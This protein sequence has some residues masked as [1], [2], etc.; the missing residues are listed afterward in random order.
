MKNRHDSDAR[1]ILA[2]T[3]AQWAESKS[4]RTAKAA[5]TELERAQGAVPSMQRDPTLGGKVFANYERAPNPVLFH[6]EQDE[7]RRGE[8]TVLREVRL[9]ISRD[10]R[11][12]IE[13][14]NG[15]GKT[16]LL[17]ALV[18]ESTRPDRILHL[19]QE[20]SEGEVQ[21]A[22][23]ELR[24]LAPEPRGQLLS[25]FAA[26]GSDP[27]RVLRA[28]AQHLSPGEARKLV[29]AG[30]LSRQ[31]WALVMDEPTN[32]MDLPSVERLEAAL[33][34]YPGCI[35]LVTHDD[36]FAENLGARSLRLE[37]GRAR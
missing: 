34:S 13:G 27:A 16:T 25:I 37:D 19:P 36:A 15:V 30:A 33:Q 10:D 4:G 22:L 2:S 14:P 20:L 23:S 32:H 11:L 6:L 3:K 26:L 8:H 5:R 12:R 28:D 1:S 7:L 31:V 21:H 29:L 24:A 18:R 9:T 35:V 17:D